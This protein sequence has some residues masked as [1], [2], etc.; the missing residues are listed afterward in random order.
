MELIM[1]STLGYLV[2]LGAQMDW[3]SW[4]VDAAVAVIVRAPGGIAT[5]LSVVA[6]ITNTAPLSNV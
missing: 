6:G 3:P 2:S 4:Q 5:T 1:H